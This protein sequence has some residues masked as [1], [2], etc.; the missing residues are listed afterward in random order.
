M[1]SDVAAALSEA[2][3]RG[4]QIEPEALRLLQS[5][6]VLNVLELI[7]KV[8]AEKEASGEKSDIIKEEDVKRVIPPGLESP[9]PEEEGGKVD[10]VVEELKEEMK[11]I[12]EPELAKRTKEGV[13]TLQ[14]LFRSRYD[15]LL[16]IAKERQEYSALE[17]I[18]SAS[19]DGGGLVRRLGGLVMSKKMGKN[20]VEL[21]I[22]DHSGSTKV[23]GFD[24]ATRRVASEVFLDQLVLVEFQIT[25]RGLA[26]AK[27]I[28][29]PDIPERTPNTAKKDVYV[30]LTS[31][32][33][34]GS[35]AFLEGPFRRFLLWVSGKGEGLDGAHSM[36]MEIVRRL[37]Y[38][39][40]CGDIV[41]GIGVYPEQERELEENDIH[42]QFAKVATLLEGV[43]K[44]IRVI[45]VPGNHDPVRQALP[46][47]RLPVSYAE[48]LYKFENVTL[49]GN[50][51]EVSLH[52]VNILIYHGQSIFD[53]VANTPGQTFSKPASA[54][55]ALLRARH[56]AP[57]YGARTP[58]AFESEDQL[59]IE[60]VP[61]I[62]HS[63][64]IHVLDADKYR[65]TL[66]VNSGAWQGKTKY[67]EIMGIN[68]TPGIVPIV[69]LSTLEIITKDFTKSFIAA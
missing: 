61:D 60:R 54:M 57:I 46:Q 28:N 6:K 39:I 50:P 69:N 45:V 15:K 48:S 68:P 38:I 9:S 62:F 29:H 32:I 51:S 44:H 4:Y 34:V 66:I 64:H 31:D 67:Q 19:R 36:D 10:L 53:V 11:V 58:I 52:G 33:H 59:V 23:F 49:L 22:D 17:P 20:R 55:K 1:S 65:G 43:P 25:R 8:L 42:K 63:G 5:L 24:D 41:D 16:K 18:A 37:K 3:A 30:V 13:A 40:I 35:R 12:S 14:S 2:L 21:T 56:L 26:V 47:P 7:G 27:S